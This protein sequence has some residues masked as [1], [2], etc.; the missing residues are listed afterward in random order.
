MSSEKDP[1]ISDGYGSS[2]AE[3]GMD[4]PTAGDVFSVSPETQPVATSVGQ[5]LRAAREQHVMS[6]P[7]VARALK[8]SLGQVEALEADDWSS[9]PGKTIIRGFVRNYA[10]LL[11]LDSNHL[12]SEL[13][14]LVLPQT[15]ELK[16]SAGTPV[17]FS[18]EA[19]TVQ[20][21]YL[22]VFSGVIILALAVL[23]YFLLPPDLWQSTLAAIKNA[24][25]S[26]KVMPAQESE[27]VVTNVDPS[28]GT[29]VVPL[30]P[31]VV[32][33]D[34][35]VVTI[36]N[37]L[38]PAA[39]PV[40]DLAPVVMPEPEPEPEPEVL[41]PPV[42]DL[43]L[44]F[45]FKQAAWLEVR[46]RDGKVIFSQLNQAGSQRTVTGEPPYTLIIGNAGQVS[47]RYKGDLVDLSKRSKD[48]VA[49]LTLE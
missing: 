49:R 45:S 41:P 48:D 38:A 20:H 14:H 6:I 31:P 34:N 5:A 11:G 2:G 9:L 19:K 1:S 25:Q 17:K 15:P 4:G 13:D 36:E 29:L 18:Q 10:R 30:A 21:D 43:S 24:A 3:I 44:N 7:D 23:A 46:D 27:P 37:P 26:H 42:E 35:S 16:M 33:P 28:S 32:V 22:R 12:M 40:L 47:L 8:L 39:S